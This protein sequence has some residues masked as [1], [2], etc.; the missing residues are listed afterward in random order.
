MPV[1]YQVYRRGP[2]DRAYEN[3]R[4]QRLAGLLLQQ[5]SYGELV[6][7]GHLFHQTDK[8]DADLSVRARS[9]TQSE[10][11]TFDDFLA[12]SLHP[13]PFLLFEILV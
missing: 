7:V 4:R 6:R 3:S 2:E 9:R 13:F 10:A 5:E 1:C 11:K 8:N 12:G